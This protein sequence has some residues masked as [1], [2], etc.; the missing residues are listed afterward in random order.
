MEMASDKVIRNME[1]KKA[2]ILEAATALFAEKGY[3]STTMGDIAKKA[4]VG[5]GTVATHFGSKEELFYTC[6]IQPWQP[7]VD[8]LLAFDKNPQSYRQEIEEMTKRHVKLFNEQK[9]YMH[10][11]VQ[12]NAQYEKFPDIFKQLNEETKVL[13]QSLIQLITN[14][15]KENQ[16]LDGNP[17]TIAISYVSLLFGLRLIYIDNLPE[18]MLQQFATVAMRLFGVK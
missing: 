1:L 10:L 3:D 9:T 17:S 13:N 4:E 12:A 11:I 18:E 8:E 7:L 15:Q 6:V 5:F 2:R 16:L 14:G